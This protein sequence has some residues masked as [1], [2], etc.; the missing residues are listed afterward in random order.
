MPTC[1]PS[2]PIARKRT[3]IAAFRTRRAGRARIEVMTVASKCSRKIDYLVLPDDDPL[4]LPV[5]PL[6]PLLLAP[7]APLLSEPAA[8]LSGLAAGAWARPLFG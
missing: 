1:E 2:A 4:L 6:V 5:L 3:R 8:P 7:L